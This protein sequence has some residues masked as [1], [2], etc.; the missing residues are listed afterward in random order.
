MST[1]EMED[2][3]MQTLITAVDKAS[4]QQR[5]K[6]ADPDLLVGPIGGRFV[7]ESDTLM[8]CESIK[9]H[10]GYENHIPL[11]VVSQDGLLYVAGGR[12]RMQPVTGVIPVA[13]VPYQDIDLSDIFGLT[14]TMF[15]MERD[16][17]L[18]VAAVEATEPPSK[19]YSPL[20]DCLLI[21]DILRSFRR[22]YRIVQQLVG[23]RK[24]C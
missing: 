21:G 7:N 12:H 20:Q 16:G 13:H 11:L 5:T 4:C 3:R 15:S 6:W 22:Q 18:V 10:S 24:V 2:V 9:N 8:I 14:Q 23:N 1:V 17:A 19:T